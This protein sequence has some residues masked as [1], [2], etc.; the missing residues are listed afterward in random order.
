VKIN[1]LEIHNFR[2]IKSIS[3]NLNSENAVIWGPNGS[4][5]S[6]VVDAIDFVLTGKI[7]RLIG[8]GTMGVTLAKHGPHVDHVNFAS[9]AEVVAH[10]RI[11]G[12]PQEVILSRTVGDPENLSVKGAQRSELDAVLQLAER[13]QHS[14]SRREILKY[15][16]AQAA[17]RSSEVQAILD[18]SE[19]ESTRKAFVSATNQ[20]KDRYKKAKASLESPEAVLKTSLSLEHFSENALLKAVNAV[21]TV[22][23]AK[24]L[25]ALSETNSKDGVERPASVAEEG[26]VN[27][28]LLEKTIKSLVGRHEEEVERLVSLDSELR[29]LITEVASDAAAVKSHSKLRLLE[30]G[31]GLLDESGECP[32]C[33]YKWP[34]GELKKSVADGIVKAKEVGPLLKKIEIRCTSLKN[35]AVS[36]RTRLDEVR[37]A[38]EVLALEDEKK[39]TDEWIEKLENFRK[40]CDDPLGE[41]SESEMT[42]S[43]L[44]EVFRGSVFSQ[45]CDEVLKQAKLNC[46]TVTLEQTAWD[47]LTKVEAT[48]PNYTAARR[49]HSIALNLKGR[50]EALSTAFEKVREEQLSALYDSIGD[51]FREFYT[52]LHSGDEDEFAATLKAD[53]KFLVDFYGRGQHPPL[54]LHSEGHQDSMG[55]CLYLAL[56]ERLTKDTCQLTVLDDVVMSVDAGHRRGVCCLL[57]KYF[58]D[59]QFL[60]TTHDRTWA[61]QLQMEGVVDRTGSFEFIRWS[62][63]SGP[64]LEIESELWANIEK[65]LDRSDTV[66]AAARLRN[67]AE[68]FFEAVCDSLCAEVRYKSSGKWE[69]GDFMPAAVHALKDKLKKG[70]AAEQSW[71]N[72]EKCE[73]LQEMDSVRTQVV[74]RTRCEQWAV[75]ATVHYNRWHELDREELRPV[76]EAFRDCFSLFRCQN[77]NSLIRV[78]EENK[79][80]TIVSCA[81]QKVTWNLVIKD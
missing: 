29:K 74:E 66:S 72:K 37:K 65:D 60:I 46:P 51:R 32:L 76:V 23:N 9:S 78:V 11:P 58:A 18:L 6:A 38:A 33:G 10:L 3:L 81:C 45:I 54:A 77:C 62:I 27:P 79:R 17:K 43:R 40:S 55:L 48:L 64:Q 67:G 12:L 30:L 70:K 75:N 49:E 52:F 21:R 5:K 57:K 41:Y 20:I 34:A 69:L 47:T 1:R 59:R 73:L 22:L 15:I 44:E 53:G 28:Q 80:A 42:A 7:P 4:G 25:A 39:K 63:D 19:L 31:I 35:E 71:G 56:A 26:K 14:L 50:A 24:E 68:Q 36:I 2:G 16:A 8:E 13:R 61:R